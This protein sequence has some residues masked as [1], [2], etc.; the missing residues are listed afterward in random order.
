MMFQRF[1]LGLV[2][3]GSHSG[4]T[5]QSREKCPPVDFHGSSLSQQ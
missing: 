3:H 1:G 2:S 4:H 5:A